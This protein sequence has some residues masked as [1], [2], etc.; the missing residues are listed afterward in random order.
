[1]N[2]SWIERLRG[3]FAVILAYIAL[4]SFSLLVLS[5]IIKTLKRYYTHE[6][7]F[8]EAE[9]VWESVRQASSF[10]PGRI[11]CMELS[12]S[13]MFFAFTK[14]LS[15]TWCI[16]VKTRPFEAHAWIEISNKPFKE[17]NFVEQEYKKL[18]VI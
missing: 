4:K 5:K 3:L 8:E 17:P 9:I 12:L 6:I 13:F 10:F 11:A 1:M 2:L 15:A 14:G 16:G 7:Q 18:L